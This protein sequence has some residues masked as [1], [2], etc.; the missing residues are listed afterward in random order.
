MTKTC[1]CGMKSSFYTVCL[2]SGTVHI[3]VSCN[4][5]YILKAKL[6]PYEIIIHVSSV[7]SLFICG[8]QNTKVNIPPHLT[9]Q[10]EVTDDLLSQVG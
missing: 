5:F 6:P 8:A 10:K 2:I 4:W 7:V 9:T 1:Q 3:T